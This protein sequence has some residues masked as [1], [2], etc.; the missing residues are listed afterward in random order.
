LIKIKNKMFSFQNHYFNNL[1]HNIIF[2]NKSHKKNFS[3]FFQIKT[4]KIYIN[5]GI[6]FRWVLQHG[7]QTWGQFLVQNDKFQ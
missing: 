7:N 5:N 3:H 6:Y 4:K 2:K 1:K